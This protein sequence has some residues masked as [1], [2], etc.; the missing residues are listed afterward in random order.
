MSDVN[1]RIKEIIDAN[2]VVVFMKGNAL[3]PRCGFSGTTVDVMDRM[4]V[5][6]KDVDVLLDE[7]I[8]EGIK[9]YS[10]WPTIPQ[11]YVKGEFLGGCDIMKEMFTSGELGDFLKENNV[12][13]T[14]S[15]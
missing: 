5:K 10:D 13:F 4:G 3:F 7:E 8:R 14:P 15:N 12:A 6:F 1:T 9:A 11:V 2:D